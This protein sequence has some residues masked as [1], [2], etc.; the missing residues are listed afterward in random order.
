MRAILKQT[1]WLF[2][3]QALSRIIGFFYTIF[4]ARNLGVSDFG[5]YAAALAYFSLVS[6]IAD[7]GFNR[8]LIREIARDRKNLPELLCNIGILRL[9]LGAVIFAL[10]A[11]GLYVL[12]PDKLRVSLVLL[13]IIAVLPQGISQTVD[14]IFI[15]IQKMEYS[16]L[17]LVILTLVT[18]IF[19]VW[20]INT[21]F[22]PAGA[23]VALVIGQVIYL[24]CLTLLLK[25]QHLTTLTQVKLPI[26]KQ[27]IWGSLPY[28]VLGILGLL[29]FRIDTL[30]LSYLRGNFEVGVYALSYRFLET[31]V[32]IPS[33]FSVALFPV[34]AKLPSAN[35]DQIKKLFFQSIKMMAILG[36]LVM[37]GYI[38]ILPP[39]IELFLPSY[40]SSIVVIKILSLAIPFIFLH[41]SAAQVVLAKEMYLRSLIVVSFLPLTL[42]VLL[43]LLF[44]PQYGYLAA[45]WITV[46]SDVFS[47]LILFIF[48]HKYYFKNA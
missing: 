32:L 6:A 27:V 15:A 46:I 38:L 31:V 44:I 40:Q 9:I 21:G 12:D 43:N 36:L 33:T 14:A 10:F 4:L 5:L 30:L 35:A 7:F 26:L 29:Y 47:F 16:S 28:G 11:I 45:S 24:L 17:G 48:I 22:G 25:M 41:V 8:F 3:A 42:N 1:S 20:L 13:A 18:T 2:L 37:L 19:G 34:M 23:V 39:V